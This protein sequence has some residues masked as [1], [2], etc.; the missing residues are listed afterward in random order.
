MDLTQL[1]G[2]IDDESLKEELETCRNS[3]ADSQKENGRHTVFN[4]GMETLG[5]HTLSQKLDTVSES[6]VFVT[7]MN[8]AFGFMLNNLEDGTSRY[9]HAYENIAFMKRSKFGTNNED[10]VK[11]KSVFVK[12][13]VFVA[14]TKLCAN[15]MWKFHK[16]RTAIVFAA[17]VREVFL[18]CRDA[19]TSVPLTK[20]NSAIYLTYAENK[21]N[22]TKTIYVYLEP[23]L[24]FRK[25]VAILKKLQSC[26]IVSQTEL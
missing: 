8:V 19:V 6:L 2:E 14:C 3:L 17:P 22:R 12:T 4:Y 26:S 13:D 25:E 16:V 20:N 1:N 11:N 21:K 24:S 23:S 5:A 7:K 10:L 18:D 15:K 9:Y